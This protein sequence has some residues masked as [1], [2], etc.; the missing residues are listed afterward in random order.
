[1]LNW[2]IPKWLQRR[3]LFLLLG[4]L[5]LGLVL[6]LGQ[7]KGLLSLSISDL[8]SSPASTASPPPS[9]QSLQTPVSP[10]PPAKASRKQPLEEPQ[11]LT[12]EQKAQQQSA[13]TE[14]Q[15][16]IPTVDSLIE[17]K[18]AI[19]VSVPSITMRVSKVSRLLNGDGAEIATLSPDTSY[20]VAGGSSVIVDGDA[21]SRIVWVEPPVDGVFYLGDRTYRGRLLLA[22]DGG[23]L[24]VV[25]VVSLRSYLHSVVASEVS[26]SWN[27]EALKAQA[28]AARSYALTYYFQPV[29][30]LYDLGDD[31]YFQVYSGIDREAPATSQAV[32]DTA[33]EFVSYRG[34]VV[35]SLYAASDDIVMEAFQGKG[36]SQ[37]GA[38][39]LAEQGYAYPE[40]L[41]TYYPSTAVGRIEQD[42]H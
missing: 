5:I 16:S 37:L 13:I 39:E 23:T 10:S 32:D 15:A 7:I 8:G 42:T 26:P 25:N 24:W 17:M 11:E 30:A 38:L 35:E 41:A 2:R 34:G 27:P 22:V 18:V 9:P 14:L 6:S 21:I 3:W 36:M 40:I 33:G 20:R 29:N 12:A 31:E 28:V 19:E 1:M 4:I